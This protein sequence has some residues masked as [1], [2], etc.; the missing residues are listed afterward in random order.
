AHLAP[1]TVWIEILRTDSEYAPPV[2]LGQ[3]VDTTLI[4]GRYR[5]EVFQLDPYGTERGYRYTD[6][7]G[8]PWIILVLLP[9]GFADGGPML[10]IVEALL[11]SIDHR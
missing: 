6:E 1:G 2:D 4:G 7:R 3:P 11:A 9:D 10:E 5:A 8:R